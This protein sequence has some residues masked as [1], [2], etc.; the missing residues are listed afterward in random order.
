L[1]RAQIAFVAG[2]DTLLASS[3]IALHG[4]LGPGRRVFTLEQP[5]AIDQV[6]AR[7]EGRHVREGRIRK[8]LYDQNVDRLHKEPFA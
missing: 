2:A 1:A 5:A 6:K 8:G 4:P 3:C 7:I